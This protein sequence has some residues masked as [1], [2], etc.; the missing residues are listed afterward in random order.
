MFTK[1]LKSTEPVLKHR[2]YFCLLQLSDLPSQV[3]LQIL[4]L[5]VQGAILLL[6]T[7]MVLL[8]LGT[9]VFEFSEFRGRVLFATEL[10]HDLGS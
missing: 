7:L 6:E 5:F 4:H 1:V 3:L 8:N 2:I 9:S 10:L